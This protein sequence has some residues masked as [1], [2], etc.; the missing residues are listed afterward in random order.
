MPRLININLGPES[1]NTNWGP[2]LFNRNWGTGPVNANWGP[3]L[4]SR[5]RAE[6]QAEGRGP[7][8]TKIQTK[9][10][11]N[12]STVAITNSQI[13]THEQYYI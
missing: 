10:T 7:G 11:A 1:I 2:G 8:N 13:R 9:D 4:G 5:A 3:G 6:T 12:V